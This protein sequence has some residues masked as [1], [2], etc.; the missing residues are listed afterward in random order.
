MF[1]LIYAH[2]LQIEGLKYSG[3]YRMFG[4]VFDVICN[5]TY[6][7]IDQY[8]FL[9]QLNLGPTL[10]KNSFLTKFANPVFTVFH[11]EQDKMVF[12]NFGDMPS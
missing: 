11:D 8:F 9:G 3:V 5:E 10:I 7:S 6:T 1:K 12:V 2:D 4:F